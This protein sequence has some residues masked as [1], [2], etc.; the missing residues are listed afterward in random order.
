MSTAVKTTDHEHIRE[1]VERNNGRPARIVGTGG[2]DDPGM[3]RID[4]D[5]EDKGLEPISWQ[6]W[7]EAFEKNHLALLL[8]P[9]SRFNKLVDRGEVR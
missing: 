1:W 4:F 5:E 3:L 7:F 9:D 2:G 6:E 8:S